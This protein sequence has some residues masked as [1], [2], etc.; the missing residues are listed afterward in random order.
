[1]IRVRLHQRSQKAESTVALINVVFLMLI[2]F[3]IAGTLA[4]TGDRA[5]DLVALTDAD[6]ASPPDMLF[7]RADGTLT[8]RGEPVDAADLPAMAP[9]EAGGSEAARPFRI[10][11]DRALPAGK[12]VETI[13]TLRALGFA[14]I[15]VV[16]RKVSP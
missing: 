12:L 14:D 15:A 5:V 2:F 1:M 4:P 9:G 16:T 6:A 7:I 13:G 11:A 8:W 3:L 10:A